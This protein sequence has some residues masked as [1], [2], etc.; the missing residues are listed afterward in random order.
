MKV[1]IVKNDKNEPIGYTI[2]GETKDEKYTINTIRNLHFFGLDDSVIKYDG[3]EAVDGE[4]KF[5]GKVKWI[6]AQ[7]QKR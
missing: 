2:E 6:Q 4:H 3:R 5:A 1:E 7:Y